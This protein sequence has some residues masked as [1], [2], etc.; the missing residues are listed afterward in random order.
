MISNHV[1]QRVYLQALNHSTVRVPGPILA[2][3][4]RE[5]AK[6]RHIRLYD[7]DLEKAQAKAWTDNDIISFFKGFKR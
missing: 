4:L 7:T 5:I 1:I 2:E 3:L 6:A